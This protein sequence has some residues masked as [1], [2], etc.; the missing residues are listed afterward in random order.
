MAPKAHAVN[1]RTLEICESIGVS[2]DGIR[3][4]GA[5][6]ND[7]GYVR[8]VGTLCGMEFGSLP[9]E[10]QDESVLTDTPYPLTNV[11]Q[12][13][14]EAELAEVI[15]K[16]NNIT[17]RRGI[18]CSRLNEDGDS[19]V[20][21]TLNN[22]ETSDVVNEKFEYVIAADGA[23][24]RI[25]EAIG[26]NMVGPEA[27]QCYLMVHFT[28]DLSHLTKHRKGVLY[29]LFEP[30]TNGVL[31]AYDQKSTW[32]LMHPWQPK[33]EDVAQYDDVKCLGLIERAV[34][35]P[36]NATVEN[37]SP[38]VMSAQVAERY[39][40]GRV[41]LVGDA[42][43]RFPPAGGLGLNTGVVDAQNLTWKLAAVLKGEAGSALLDSYEVERQPVAI[44]NSDQSLANS[45][46]LFDLRIALH[47][48][49]PIDAE[50]RYAEVAAQPEKF[51]ELAA[52]VEAQ[53]PHF[54]SLNLQLG[55]RYSSVAIV[56]PAPLPDMSDVS[57][58][59]PSWES[60]AHFPHRRVR[61]GNT[62][63]AL[64]ACMSADKFNLLYGPEAEPMTSEPLTSGVS[65]HVVTF[66][67]DFEDQDEWSS[68]TGLPN[69]GAILIRPDGHIAARFEETN[70]DFTT[71]LDAAL[72]QILALEELR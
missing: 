65:L 21:V 48:V 51:P 7:A 35:C 28:A 68:L 63:C 56:D 45:A 18:E 11:P 6:A 59:Q 44:V 57:R 64:M 40:A 5:N 60:G 72:N 8:F 9:Y 27:I 37:V 58:Y 30:G 12:P 24:S 15:A 31:I 4:L 46:K 26:I 29:F 55:Y 33:V 61:A 47:G 70:G 39:R 67:H 52:A 66:G 71:A 38:W 62:E 3:A 41:F 42:A 13:V 54:N 19:A 34:G 20:S 14:F 53:R 49:H 2:A 43:H 25:R 36:V 23:G 32:V 16:D 10:R 69:R 22:L 50:Q 17:F 1:P